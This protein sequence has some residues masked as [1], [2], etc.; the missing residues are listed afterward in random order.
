M[1]E[2]STE[3][4]QTTEIKLLFEHTSFETALVQEDY[5]YGNLRCKRACWIETAIKGAKKGQMRF[6]T[7]TTN[8]RSQDKFWNSP[9][10]G[11]YSEIV[12]MYVNP[13]NGHIETDGCSY[14]LSSITTFRSKWGTL[15]DESLTLKLD[16]LEEDQKRINERFSRPDADL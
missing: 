4:L 9:H 6:V 10:P 16:Q 7:R 14:S 3:M 1:P 5:P 15:L 11:G 2:P 12:V 13:E 8:P